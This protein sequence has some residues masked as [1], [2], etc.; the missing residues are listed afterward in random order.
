MSRLS[1]HRFQVR[2]ALFPFPTGPRPQLRQP[3]S[4]TLTTAVG[5]SPVIK[6]PMNRVI[7]AATRCWEIRL[8]ALPFLRD[9][10][11][12]PFFPSIPVAEKERDVT[13]VPIK[14]ILQVLQ[15][16]RSKEG[17]PSAISPF[18]FSVHRDSAAADKEHDS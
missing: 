2:I 11:V 6:R 4:P 16:M 9:M 1:Q 5:Q 14:A 15:D 3:R 13:I 8:R 17:V 7:F 18:C 12:M 10:P